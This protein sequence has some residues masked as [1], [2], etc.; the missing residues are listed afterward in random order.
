MEARQV[1]AALSVMRNKSDK[2]DARGIAKN[3][4]SGW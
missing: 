4:R 3:L 2:H 1:K